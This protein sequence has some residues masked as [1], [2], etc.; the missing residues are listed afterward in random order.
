MMADRE[1]TLLRPSLLRMF[2]F[3]AIAAA[4]F[5]VV[6]SVLANTERRE[7][8]LEAARFSRDGRTLMQQGQYAEA[9]DAFRSAIA[10]ARENTDYRLALGEALLGAKKLD[11]AGVTL[12]E[13]L[14][15]DSM[16]GAP[17]LA[18]ARVLAKEGRFDEAAAYYHRAIYGKWKDD[19][20]GNQAKARFEL[21]DFLSARNAKSALLGELLP[22][23]EQAPQDL[24][25]Q[26]RLARLFMIAGSPIRAS[27]IFQTLVR[28]NPADPD[29]QEDLA[30]TEFALRDFP[31][32]QAALIAALRLRPDDQ[33]AQRML[34][35]C[36]QVLNLDPMRR[37]LDGPERYRRSLLVLQRV[38]DR[39]V[40]CLAPGEANGQANASSALIDEAQA[41]LKKNVQTAD[42]STAVESNLEIAGKLWQAARAKCPSPG[43]PDDPLQLVLTKPGQ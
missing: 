4:A 42:Q 17:N 15:S 18:M 2:V 24:P 31:A 16:A 21:A 20:A 27:A 41:A 30:S 35:L 12:T 6:D 19:P 14:E 29:L 33:N 1:F 38:S 13:L 25:T 28:A 10:N 3:A 36:D 34:E 22:L 9:A 32:A 40:E 11:E 37:G 8:S 43:S 7:T 23:Q 39:A 26:T 5:V